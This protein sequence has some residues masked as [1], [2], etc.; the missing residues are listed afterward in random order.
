MPATG[1]ACGRWV[2][3][4]IWI[5]IWIWIDSPQKNSV[6]EYHIDKGL[7]REGGRGLGAGTLQLG[8]LWLKNGQRSQLLQ[9]M[10]VI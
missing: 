7:L 3:S 10:L 1:P 6:K 5:W 2:G 8:Q 9:R 4:W